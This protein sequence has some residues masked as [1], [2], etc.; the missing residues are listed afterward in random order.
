MWSPYYQI[1]VEKVESVQQRFFRFLACKS[2][3]RMSSLMVMNT[4]VHIFSISPAIESIKS[5]HT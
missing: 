3:N 2:G 4:Q 5:K 1:D